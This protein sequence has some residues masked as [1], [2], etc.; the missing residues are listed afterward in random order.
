MASAI[1]SLVPNLKDIEAYRAFLNIVLSNICR[2]GRRVWGRPA[3]SV[4]IHARTC[5]FLLSEKSKHF[6]APLA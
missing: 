6:N 5:D 3:L 4:F 1:Q 2:Q